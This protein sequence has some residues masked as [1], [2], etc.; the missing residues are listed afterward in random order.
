MTDPEGLP[1]EGRLV[2]RTP[3]AIASMLRVGA[4]SMADTGVEDRLVFAT[5]HG[6]NTWITRMNGDEREQFLR[7]LGAL[8]EVMDELIEL[9]WDAGTW[10]A[11]GSEERRQMILRTISVPDAIAAELQTRASR[12]QAGPPR[13][14]WFGLIPT[15]A[16]CTTATSS[17]G[18]EA[19]GGCA[20][21]GIWR[22][23]WVGQGQMCAPWSGPRRTGDRCS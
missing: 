15:H 8:V 16:R 1:A 2:L 14:R 18:P 17:R 3:D 9:P 12:C 5:G 21:A 20:T 23:R 19:P 13:A 6:V 22:P 7:R 11:A 10:P 4:A